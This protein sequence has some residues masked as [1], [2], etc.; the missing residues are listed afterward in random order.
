MTNVNIENEKKYKA[1]KTETF[2]EKYSNIVVYEYRGYKYEVEYA[3]DMSYCVT[4]PKVQHEN[5][6]AEIDRMIEK[7]NKGNLKDAN[8]IDWDEIYN[9]LGWN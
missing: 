6:Q 2:Y 1:N 4:S 8:P 9:M 7:K 5:K 3:K